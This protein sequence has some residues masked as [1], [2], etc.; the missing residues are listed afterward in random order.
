MP[1]VESNSV[2]GR[3]RKIK[4]L[5][6]QLGIGIP[7]AV[8]HLHLLWHAVIEQA[9]DGDL[10]KWNCYAVAECSM[11]EG[12]ALT[13]LSALQENGLMDSMKIHDWLDYAGVYLVTKYKTR[14]RAKLVEI[15]AK[16]GRAYGH[17]SISRD[18][19]AGSTQGS[20]QGSDGT[21]DR[22]TP[23]FLTLPTLPPNHKSGDAAESFP[24]EVLKI[25][26]EVQA[27]EADPE[28]GSPTSLLPRPGK[29]TPRPPRNSHFVK[30]TIEQVGDYLLELNSE[31]DPQHWM[32][33]QISR[34]WLVGKNRTPMADWK[35]TIRTWV[36]MSQDKVSSPA[37]PSA[38]RDGFV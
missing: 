29:K 27:Q 16:F 38:R 37:T 2:I 18:V 32:D 6:R 5:A 25:G 20:T 7:Q 1:W 9:E 36:K 23:P 35:A 31:I 30:P 24:R 3:H 34:G 21:G 12:D 11:W 10:S 13:F 15:W 8:G 19:P 33:T 28:S 14:N 22:E 26:E 17:E 4:G